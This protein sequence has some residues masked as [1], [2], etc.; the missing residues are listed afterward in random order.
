[1]AGIGQIRKLAVNQ[2]Q[3]QQLMVRKAKLK[4]VN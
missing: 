3:N 2:Q 1:L 4:N